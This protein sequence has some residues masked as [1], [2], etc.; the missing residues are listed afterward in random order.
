MAMFVVDTEKR[1]GSEF[2]SNIYHVEADD[3]SA[4]SALAED[5]ADLEL[6]ILSSAATL[7]RYRVRTA[8]PNDETYIITPV[9]ELGGRV[10][11]TTLLPLFNTL[12]IDMPASVGRPSRKYYRAVLA[13]GDING[14][15]VSTDFSTFIANLETLLWVSTEAPGIVDPQGQRLTQA[16]QHPFV[17]MRQLRRSRRRRTNGQG[18]FQ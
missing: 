2:W 9:G 5:I 17:Q 8:D 18:I 10:N 15:A 1:L 11:Q 4:A 13:E 16:V 3:L 6:T 14:D 7:T 12:R